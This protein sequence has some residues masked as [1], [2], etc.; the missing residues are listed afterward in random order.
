MRSFSDDKLVE[1]V[2]NLNKIIS[3]L[4]K[5]NPNI[6]PLRKQVGLMGAELGRR[7]ALR[8]GRTFDDATIERMKSYFIENAGLPEYDDDE[9]TRSSHPKCQDS[10]I[11][12]LNKGKRELHGEELKTTNETIEKA[13]DMYRKHGLAGK[14]RMLTFVDKKDKDA[15]SGAR[16]P[17]HLKDNVQVFDVL[18][19]MANHDVGWSVF[20]LSIL[21]GHHSV[22]LTLDNNDP[23]NPKI[24]WS[25][26]WS[27]KG[28]WKEYGKTDLQKEI[29]HL[30]HKW[31]D[32]DKTP[33][34]ANRTY[35]GQSLEI[36]KA[37]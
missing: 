29:Q 28:G 12:T 16:E 34:G 31:W 24:Y 17:D 6:E 15:T 27:S 18:L 32:E 22:T 9:H 13:M 35:D 10:C 37:N 30:T 7:K 19:D 25:D 36:Y 33:S 14:A 1:M 3:N 23:S 4:N 20:G 21:D 26:Q 2:D 5:D 8:E 11:V